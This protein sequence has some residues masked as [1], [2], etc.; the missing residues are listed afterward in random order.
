MEEEQREMEFQ[1][2]VAQDET[3]E[4]TDSFSR[5]TGRAPP[6]RA[7]VSSR[8]ERRAFR[9]GTRFPCET[10]RMGIAVHR[11]AEKAQSDVAVETVQQNRQA[12]AIHRAQAPAKA[13]AGNEHPGEVLGEFTQPRATSANRRLPQRATIDVSGTAATSD[14]VWFD[15]V[16]HACRKPPPFHF[17]NCRSESLAL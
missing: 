9:R 14:A 7:V 3:H 16:C 13:V 15:C 2:D 1:P 17:D 5:F 12:A 4:P 11:L 8:E 10:G 6:V